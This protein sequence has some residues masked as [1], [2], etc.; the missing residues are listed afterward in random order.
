MRGV[1]GGGEVR[2]RGTNQRGSPWSLGIEKP[3]E[4]GRTLQRTVRLSDE[5]LATSG[6]YRNY[7]EENGV[8]LS[9]TIDPR[10]G[11][12]VAH[13][14]ASVSVI[15]PICMYADAYAT[16]LMALGP[17]DGLAWAEEQG[18]AALFI[19]RVGGEFEERAT[20][21]FADRHGDG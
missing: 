5:S 4:T 9:H 3:V 20:A 12:P 10:T 18:L 13:S 19:V 7:Y 8:R 21:K 2:A 1:D 14:L 11:R 16:A 6:D 17:E 15:H